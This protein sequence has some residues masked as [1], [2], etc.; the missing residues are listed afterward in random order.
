[1]VKLLSFFVVF[2]SGL[3]AGGLLAVTRSHLPT[4]AFFDHR[5]SLE[6]HVLFYKQMHPYMVPL[7]VTT[8]LL[9]VVTLVLQRD[10]GAA[11]ALV[12]LGIA[13]MAGLIGTTETLMRPINR[14]AMDG[15][16]ADSAAAY[17]DA[18]RRWRNAQLVR[19]GCA[20]AAFGCF[21]ASVLV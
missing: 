14:S 20:I 9:A 4:L 11:M 13:G 15:S 8:T 2:G 12:A 3:V 16:L 1:M 5:A 19:T 7:G 18:R 17:E 6:L 21:I 10:H